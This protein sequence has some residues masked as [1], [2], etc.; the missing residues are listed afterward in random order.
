M[1]DRM[2]DRINHTK[3]QLDRFR[4]FGDPGGRKSLSPIDWRY[5]P[6]NCVRT[7][8][9]HCDIWK[10]QAENGAINVKKLYVSKRV[11]HFT[12]RN[13]FPGRPSVFLNDNNCH[14]Q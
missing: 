1:W 13:S 14:I 7:N 11:S 12:D 3:F 5:C 6:Y 10:F 4:G 9:L 8:V 2:L